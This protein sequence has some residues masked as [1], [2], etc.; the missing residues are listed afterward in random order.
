MPL[1]FAPLLSK[2]RGWSGAG[3]GS[4]PPMPRSRKP[5]SDH[6]TESQEPGRSL[7]LPLMGLTEYASIG[8]FRR[9]APR[10]ATRLGLRGNE[11]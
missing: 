2:P 10:G 7:Y 11:A 1:R 3:L 9:T 5:A 4:L 6:T 8:Y